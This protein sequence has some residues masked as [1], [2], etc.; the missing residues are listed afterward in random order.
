MYKRLENLKPTA[1]VALRAALSRTMGR[2]HGEGFV[3]D[4]ELRNAVNHAMN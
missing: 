1:K 2:S 3:T 4:E